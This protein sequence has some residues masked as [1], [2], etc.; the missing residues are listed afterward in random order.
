MKA[1]VLDKTDKI[2]NNPLKLKDID[3]KD[4]VKKE[5][6]IKNIS[7]GVCRSNLHMIEGDWN[8]YGVPG[9]LP[10]IP[11]HEIIGRVEELGEDVTVL[12]KGDMVGVQPL[13]EACG[14][15]EYCL[16]GRENLCP[17]GKYTGES[18]DGGYAE[19]MIANSDYVNKIPANIDPM[20]SPLLCP[21]V[22]AYSAIKKAEICPGKTVYIVGIGGVGHIA[23]QIAKL[24]GAHIVA[25]TTS[26]NHEELAYKMGADESVILNNDYSNSEAI[27]GSADSVVIFAPNDEAIKHSMKFVKDGGIVVQGVIGNLGVILSPR[28]LTIKGTKIGTRSEVNEVLKLA[29]SHKIKIEYKKYAL[30]EANQSLRDLKDGK[31]NGRAILT[32]K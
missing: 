2:E 32:F 6:L 5:I 16:N 4:P 29:A 25:V 14:K 20:E 15:C 18:V 27:K 1:M 28:E 30:E 13:Y 11:G 10:I 26:K 9:K 7:C 31:I 3:F 22:T 24:Y 19:Y 23:I 8:T 17:Y 21:G 12:K